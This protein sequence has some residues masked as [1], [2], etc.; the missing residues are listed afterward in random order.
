[1]QPDDIVNFSIMKDVTTT[2]CS[3][4]EASSVIPVTI[5]EC[6]TK[7]TVRMGGSIS[8]PKNTKDTESVD[9][10]NDTCLCNKSILTRCLPGIMSCLQSK[11]DAT[12]SSVNPYVYPANDLRNDLINDLTSNHRINLCTAVGRRLARYYSV[13][14]QHCNRDLGVTV[15]LTRFIIYRCGANANPEITE[16]HLVYRLNSVE[17]F[18]VWGSN[19]PN[20]EDRFNERTLLGS[21]TSYKSCGL[22]IDAVVRGDRTFVI[23]SVV[24]GFRKDWNL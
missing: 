1:M 13:I 16:D 23:N 18:E 6:K 3:A 19:D 20:P 12:V 8:L 17:L 4:R 9:S 15:T 11:I 22:P 5:K 14:P 10:I 21:L 2:L 7:I 24:L